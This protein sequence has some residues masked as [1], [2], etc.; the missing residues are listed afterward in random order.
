MFIHKILLQWIDHS[1]GLA[2]VGDDQ[3]F[4]GDDGLEAGGEVVFEVGDASGLYIWLV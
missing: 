1:D 2:V 3:G 4:A